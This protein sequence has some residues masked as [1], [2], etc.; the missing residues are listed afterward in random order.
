[1]TLQQMQIFKPISGSYLELH[2]RNESR[3]VQN[4]PL[5]VQIEAHGT[6]VEKLGSVVDLRPETMFQGPFCP[7]HR[8]TSFQHVQMSEHPHYS[9]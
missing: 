7:V 3:Q 1:M 8:F 2:N 4:I 6:E 9:W 5:V